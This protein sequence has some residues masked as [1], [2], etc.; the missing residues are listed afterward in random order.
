MEEYAMLHPS[1]T[2]TVSDLL[3]AY[4][5]EYLPKKAPT[6]QYQQRKR[7]AT[8]RRDLGFMLLADLTPAFLRSWRDLLAKR[9][10][11]GTVCRYLDS[12]SAPLTVAVK[13]YGWLTEHPLRK[14]ERPAEPPGRTR[15][16]SEEELPRLLLACRR[17]RNPHLYGLVLLAVSTGARKT[18]LRLLR[19]RDC[20][21]ERG[22]IRVGVSKR[23]PRRS[24]PLR[25][26]VLAYL[27]QQGQGQDPDGWVFARHDG[28]KPTLVD[29]VFRQACVWAKIDNLRFHDLRH[30]TAS[31]LALNGASL[32]EIQEVL[33]HAS[34]SQTARYV[35]M[36]ESHTAG[37]L[38]KM[39]DRFL[40]SLLGASILATLDSVFLALG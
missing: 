8:L 10:A 17:S 2:Y 30:T 33:G 20:D 28:L 38:E 7:F 21:L 35:H 18:Q 14:V 31:W 9:Y 29:Q 23:A 32:R 22:L 5:R 3:T 24:I 12:L 16:L 37:V 6:T 1:L 26:P 4:E 39:A 36:T 27:Q 11:P 15:F 13:Y 19:W 25:G 40:A 34:I